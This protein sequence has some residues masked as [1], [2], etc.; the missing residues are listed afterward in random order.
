MTYKEYYSVSHIFM[1][2]VVPAQFAQ[3]YVILGLG[4]EGT[5]KLYFATF[6]LLPNKTASVYNNAFHTVIEAVGTSHASI[7]IDLEQSVIRSAWEFFANLKTI[8][9][10]QFHQKKK[11]HFQVGQKGCLPYHEN[12]A[13]QVGLDLIYA[14]DRLPAEDMVLKWETV[15]VPHFEEHFNSEGIEDIKDFLGYV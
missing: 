11:L 3:M 1:L 5:S 12:A 9:G 7:S 8:V 2:Q 14:M 15:M 13:F 6:M 10:C 4:G